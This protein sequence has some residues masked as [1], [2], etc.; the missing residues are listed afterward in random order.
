MPNTPAAMTIVNA[1]IETGSRDEKT[2]SEKMIR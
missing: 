2:I 1:G